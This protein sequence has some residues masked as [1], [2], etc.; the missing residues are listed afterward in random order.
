[1]WPLGLLF[2]YGLTIEK[3]SQKIAS[4]NY[5]FCRLLWKYFLSFSLLILLSDWIDFWNTIFING[6]SSYYAGD[7]I[8][9]CSLSPAI[10][11]IHFNFCSIRLFY[12]F[13]RVKLFFR[14]PTFLS[15]ARGLGLCCWG[16]NWP[17]PGYMHP[18]CRDHQMYVQSLWLHFGWWDIYNTS[19]NE[20]L[21]SCPC[22]STFKMT[23]PGVFFRKMCVP[24]VKKFA[25]F[26]ISMNKD[27]RRRNWWLNM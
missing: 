8:I 15:I 12:I 18:T 22:K 17:K 16:Y 1:M 24:Y 9:I 6:S 23:R 19:A 13:F 25:V 10:S 3:L 21:D 5:Q 20:Q 26:V 27:F 2:L 4:N 11:L 14:R 7:C